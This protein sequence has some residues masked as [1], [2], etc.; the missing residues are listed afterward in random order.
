MRWLRPL[1]AY[2]AAAVV[3][4]W[5]LI[6]GPASLLGAPSGPGDPFLNL[7]I[8][9]WN[10]Q[11]FTTNPLSVVTGHVFDANIFHPAQGTLAYSDH[12]LL[13]SAL[14][15][16]VYAVTHDVVV[17]YNVLLIGSLV[18]SAL[19]MHAFV[20]SVVGSE[21]GAYLAGLAWGFGSYRFAHLIHLQLQSLYVLP[22]AFLCLHRV[23]AGRRSRDVVALGVLA[24]VQ[25][26]SSVYYGII[27]GL[28]LA[29][30][31]VALAVSSGRGRSVAVLRRLA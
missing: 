26:L 29:V 24:G 8:L 19:A 23:M 18:A 22:L 16:P 7:W 9:G 31:G 6:L 27:G 5:P 2:L 28:A 12:L 14:L 21:G 13:Q 3:T 17:C 30:A 4:T 1:L 25:A 20:R 10:L 11:A 15:V